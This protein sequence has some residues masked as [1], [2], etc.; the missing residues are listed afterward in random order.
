VL[1]CHDGIQGNLLALACFDCDWLVTENLELLKED[2]F[3]AKLASI[4]A[5]ANSVLKVITNDMEN[6]YVA[7]AVLLPSC[8]VPDLL[9]LP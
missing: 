1:F 2:L 4:P 8:L 6:L 5:G 3:M 7:Q 9:R